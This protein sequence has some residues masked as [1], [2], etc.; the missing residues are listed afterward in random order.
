MTFQVQHSL[1]IYVDLSL[2]FNQSRLGEIPLG[3]KSGADVV[4]LFQE[5]NEDA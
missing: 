4:N 3:H 2:T 1:G 5:L